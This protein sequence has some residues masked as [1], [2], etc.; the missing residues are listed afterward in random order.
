MYVRSHIE[1]VSGTNKY[2]Y[3]NTDDA[4][5]KKYIRENNT[6]YPVKKY[7]GV[8]KRIKNIKNTPKISKRAGGAIGDIQFTIKIY[9]NTAEGDESQ[10]QIVEI[11]TNDINIT[12]GEVLKT[13]AKDSISIMPNKDIHIFNKNYKNNKIKINNILEK[14]AERTAAIYGINHFVIIEEDNGTFKVYIRKQPTEIKKD[15]KNINDIIDTKL[16]D[17]YHVIYKR[18]NN[19]TMNPNEGANNEFI[20]IFSILKKG[21]DSIDVSNLTDYHTHYDDDSIYNAL[22]RK[23]IDT[24][25]KLFND[26]LTHSLV[27]SQEQLIQIEQQTQPQL[28]RTNTLRDIRAISQH[29]QI[30]STVFDPPYRHGG[31]QKT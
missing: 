24:L 3:I 1:N 8:L 6:Y 26:K 22:Y 28:T 23:L 17:C 21:F 14:I 10:P 18:N 25:P 30:T 11:T 7:K 29:E 5:K 31:K 12:D 16:K 4:T 20:V 9:D 19:I 27:N 2:I 13:L 15:L